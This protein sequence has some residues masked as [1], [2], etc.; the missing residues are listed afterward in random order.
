MVAWTALG[1]ITLFG[2]GLMTYTTPSKEEMLKVKRDGEGYGL[3]DLKP[4][5]STEKLHSGALCSYKFL[6]GYFMT[7]DGTKYQYCAAS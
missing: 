6:R 3:G 7:N 5:P 4:H 1:G 2:W